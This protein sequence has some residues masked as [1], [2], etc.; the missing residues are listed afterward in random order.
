MLLI[1]VY[2]FQHLSRIHVRLAFL[3]DH[4]VAERED[5]LDRGH[6]HLREIEF[7]QFCRD[8]FDM[9]VLLDVEA[10]A[11]PLLYKRKDIF[12]ECCRNNGEHDNQY[13]RIFGN[14]VQDSVHVT[15]LEY[16]ADNNETSDTH[17]CCVIDVVFLSHMYVVCIENTD[18]RAPPAAVG[19]DCTR[20]QTFD[21][22]A[23][24]DGFPL[25]ETVYAFR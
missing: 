21:A 14:D 9:R 7:V 17:H 15:S 24:F 11:K 12:L 4:A 2:E 16:A 25:S 20:T 18:E 1:T 23:E 6:E 19:I 8:I 5:D 10:F 22:I 3:Y 13:E